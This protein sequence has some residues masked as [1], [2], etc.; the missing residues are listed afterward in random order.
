MSSVMSSCVQLKLH[1]AVAG[2]LLCVMGWCV[3]GW[4]TRTGQCA[5]WCIYAHSSTLTSSGHHQYHYFVINSYPIQCIAQ[6][7]TAP[8]L[9]PAIA[10]LLVQSLHPSL[11]CL[12]HLRRPHTPATLVAGLTMLAMAC[13]PSSS[14]CLLH[15]TLRDGFLA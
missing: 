11:G 14:R 12:L 3:M 4:C 7:C 15:G 9:A 10:W 1:A 8:C 13:M 5:P 6:H 2:L